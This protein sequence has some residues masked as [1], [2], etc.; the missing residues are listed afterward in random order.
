MLP[1]SHKK[2][3][4][5]LQELQEVY[6]E[7]ESMLAIDQNQF[8]STPEEHLAEHQQHSQVRSWITMMKKTI[9][10]SKTQ[11]RHIAQSGSRHIHTYFHRVYIP[12]KKKRHRKT[13]TKKKTRLHQLYIHLN[14]NRHQ[15]LSLIPEKTSI[16]LT[17]KQL[18]PQIPWENKKKQRQTLISDW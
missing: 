17:P 6:K 16:V 9:H 13:K 4:K 10:K 18:Q 2:Q 14:P 12:A 8:Y 1:K 7:C 11:A 3:Q 15:L 5:L